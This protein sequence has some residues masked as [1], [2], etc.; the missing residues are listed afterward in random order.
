MTVS[1]SNYALDQDSERAQTA[2]A[3]FAFASS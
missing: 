3:H 1:L 2:A